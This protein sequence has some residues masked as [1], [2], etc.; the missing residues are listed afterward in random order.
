[1]GSGKQKRKA[2]TEYHLG[3]DTSNPILES[4]LQK[5]SKGGTLFPDTD[6]IWEPRTVVGPHSISWWNLP[7][8][9]TTYYKTKKLRKQEEKKKKDEERKQKQLEKAGIVYKPK[10]KK[11]K[12]YQVYVIG[13]EDGNLADIYKIGISNAPGKRLQSLNTSN[14][15]KLAIIHKFLTEPATEAEAQLH[16]MFQASR[17]SGEW[18][19]LTPE[20]IFDL[21]RIIEF[22]DGK[23]IKR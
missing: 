12:A 9:Q 6:R 20:Q 15:F 19:K 21:K 22:K 3:F 18:F 7:E 16:A 2:C 5:I 13:A 1:M 4:F 10:K 8:T 23:F 17:I 11:E 14:P